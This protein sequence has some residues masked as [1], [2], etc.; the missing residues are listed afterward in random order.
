MISPQLA[1]VR[2][3]INGWGVI[4]TG[5]YGTNYLFRVAVAKHGFGANIGQ[6]AIHA[7]TFTDSKGIPLWI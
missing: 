1:N 5:Q 6:E 4:S 3:V 7:I 2:E